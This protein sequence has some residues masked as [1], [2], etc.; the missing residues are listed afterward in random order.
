R[1]GSNLRQGTYLHET[2]L[3]PAVVRAG[4]SLLA[5][6]QIPGDKHPEAQPLFAPKVPLQDGPHD[7]ML[8]AT[9]ADQVWAFD[10]NTYQMQWARSVGRPIVSTRK[11]DGWLT[12]ENFGIV[13]TPVIDGG[14][15]YVVAWISSDGTVATA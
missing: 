12:N 3:T 15:V 2:R 5:T 9:N 11:I 1:S 7:L 10:A 8:V 4:L 14:N 13:S 6:I